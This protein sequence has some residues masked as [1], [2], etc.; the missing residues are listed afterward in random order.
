MLDGR[1]IKLI[2][3]SG[4]YMPKIGDTIICKVID[5]GFNGWRIDTNSAYSAM[6]SMKDATSDF[7]ARGANLTQYY[8]LG[9]ILSARLQCHK[10]EVI[11]VTMK[12]PD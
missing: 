1:T 2:P 12:G 5:V 11:D 7:I 10:P 4:R 9:S 6:L 8:D 3:M